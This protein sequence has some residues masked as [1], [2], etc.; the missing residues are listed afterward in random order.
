MLVLTSKKCPLWIAPN[1]ITLLGFIANAQAF[2]IA[3]YYCGLEGTGEAPS[4]V[5]FNLALSLFVYQT[6][7]AIDGKQARRTGTGEF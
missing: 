6:L 4:W 3:V 1:L 2:F 7:D 5:Y